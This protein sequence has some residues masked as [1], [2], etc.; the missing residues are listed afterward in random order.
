MVSGCFFSPSENLEK[1]FSFSHRGPR[2]DDE[3]AWHFIPSPSLRVVSSDGAEED[4]K[5]E[6]EEISD[7]R[8]HMKLNKLKNEKQKM[9]RLHA[10]KQ[11]AKD[12]T[13]TKGA[14]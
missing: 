10:M 1:T 14:K 12:L 8:A 5:E 9:I 13:S 11:M 2:L 3:D 7:L 6:S 4:A